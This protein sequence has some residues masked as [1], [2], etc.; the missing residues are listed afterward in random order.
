MT[1]L[2]RDISNSR[3]TLSGRMKRQMQ[4]TAGAM[5]AMLGPL[6]AECRRAAAA[7][8]RYHEL[9][10]KGLVML[11]PNDAASNIPR[12]IFEEFYG[13]GWRRATCRKKTGLSVHDQSWPGTASAMRA[14]WA[15]FTRRLR[16]RDERNEVEN[17]RLGPSQRR[18]SSAH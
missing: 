1:T 3:Q 17:A 2:S 16:G 12:T 9:K 10:R 11:R 5:S 7:S 18:H 8:R 14:R 15:G 4:A 13:G 6:I